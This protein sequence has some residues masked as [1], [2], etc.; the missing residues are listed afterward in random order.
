MSNILYQKLRQ[1]YS[2]DGGATWNY[3][4]NAYKA[5]DILENPSNCTSS[6]SK[7]YRWVELPISEG[8]TCDPTYT[9]YTVEVEEVSNNGGLTWTRTGNQRQAN[10]YEENSVDCGYS[11][12]IIECDDETLSFIFDGEYMTYRIN[13]K[14]YYRADKNPYSTTL[15]ELNENILT[16]CDDMFYNSSIINLEEL[17]CIDN[18][19]SMDRMFKSCNKLTTINVSD[20]NTSNVTSMSETF[21]ECTKLTSLD[22][23]N[24]DTSNVTDMYNMFYNCSGLTSLNVSNWDTSNVNKIGVM[25]QNCKALKSLDLSGWNTSKITDMGSMFQN[26]VNLTSLDISNFDTSNVTDMYGMFQNCSNL[27]TLDLSSFNTSN[28]TVISSMFNGCNDLTELDLSNFD[29]RNIITMVYLFKDCR[30]LTTLDLSNWNI[31]KTFTN[32][33]CLFENCPALKTIKMCNCNQ[34]AIDLIKNE[35]EC[36]N[37]N[38]VTIIT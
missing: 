23:S 26:C 32:C 11:G 9:K 35:L 3:V 31:T 27:T 18:V 5:G 34:A 2:L 22:L 14:T 28:V 20:W 1:Q 19:T 16:N 38:N 21:V 25:F 36:V 15:T 12:S 33:M 4:Y 24:F 30:S 8:Y 10:V 17:P 13:D 37:R 29:T 7:Q 6:D